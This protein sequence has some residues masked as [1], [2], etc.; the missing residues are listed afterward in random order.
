LTRR[1][2]FWGSVTRVWGCP[3]IPYSNNIL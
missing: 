3:K 1:V 2:D